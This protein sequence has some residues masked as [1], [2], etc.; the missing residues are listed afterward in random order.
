MESGID[1]ILKS[2]KTICPGLT[3][4]ELSHF[5][6]ILSFKELK[7]KEVFLQSGKLQKALGFIVEGLVRSSYVDN[8]GNEITVGFYYEGDYATHYPAFITRKPSQYT[9]QCLEPT[10]FVC[11][12]YDDIQTMYQKFPAFERYGRLVTEEI[13]KQQQA[14]IESFIFQ[15]AEQRYT[16]FVKDHPTLFNRISLSHLCSYLGIERQTLTRIRQKLAHQ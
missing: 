11:L 7:R 13:L 12:T 1:T 9:I 16:N 5:C 14:R 2:V 15:S 4:T 6:S 10:S 8:N 3:E